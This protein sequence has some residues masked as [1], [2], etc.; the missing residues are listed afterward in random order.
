MIAAMHPHDLGSMVDGLAPEVVKAANATQIS[1]VG[2]ITVHA[3]LKAPLKFSAGRT[4][5]R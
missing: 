3:A 4:S 2:C 1:E 5:R